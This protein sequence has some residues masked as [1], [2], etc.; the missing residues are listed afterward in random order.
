V[1]CKYTSSSF[2]K[3]L[4]NLKTSCLV[5]PDAWFLLSSLLFLKNVAKKLC[6]SLAKIPIFVDEQGVEKFASIVGRKETF[7]LE[8]LLAQ[9]ITDTQCSGNH[10]DE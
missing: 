4:P 9:E 10:A 3:A 5:F 8:F 1:S 2:S 7:S 6:V